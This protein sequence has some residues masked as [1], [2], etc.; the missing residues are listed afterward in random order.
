M[1]TECVCLLEGLL[2]SER[3]LPLF[4]ALLPPAGLS[5]KKRQ[6]ISKYQVAKL[7]VTLWDY[8]DL[9]GLSARWLYCGF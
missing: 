1:K 7:V 6:D 3:F 9:Q 4:K 8:S 5:R 2:V